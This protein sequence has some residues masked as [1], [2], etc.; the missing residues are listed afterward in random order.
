[1]ANGDSPVMV[2]VSPATCSPLANSLPL[3]SRISTFVL[4]VKRNS[5]VSIACW[6]VAVL[7]RLMVFVVVGVS[8]TGTVLGVV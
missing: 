7:G 3:E 6:V 8:A 2:N 1:M 5:K 4:A